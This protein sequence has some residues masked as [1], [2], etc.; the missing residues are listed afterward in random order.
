M[1]RAQAL[2]VVIGNSDVLAL[3]PLWRSFMNYIYTKGGWRGHRISWDPEA[4]VDDY[5][6]GVRSKAAG[7][8]EE[9]M[10]RLKALIVSVGDGGDPIPAADSDDEEIDGGLGDGLVLREED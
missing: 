1:T 9:T 2:L 6:E 5:A 8:A 10:A 3:D 7:E 4:N